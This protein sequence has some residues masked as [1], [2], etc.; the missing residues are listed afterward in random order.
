MCLWWSFEEGGGTSIASP[1]TR[2][3]ATKRGHRH[4]SDQA[5]AWA[6][7]ATDHD[8]VPESC[9]C[10]ECFKDYFTRIICGCNVI[11]VRSL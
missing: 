8:G 7:V 2:E 9:G 10:G 1:Y 3:L 4:H 6:L 5:V 11:V